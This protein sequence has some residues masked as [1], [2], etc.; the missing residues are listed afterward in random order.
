MSWS[1][2]ADRVSWSA[3]AVILDS[4][5]RSSTMP[6]SRRVSPPIR[7]A[8]PAT[9]RG[10]VTGRVSASATGRMCRACS[11]IVLIGSVGAMTSGA[12]IAVSHAPHG[13]DPDRFGRYQLDL[14][15]QPSH[16]D[17]Y[18]GLVAEVPAPH[19]LQQ[20]GP[21]ESGSGVRHQD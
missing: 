8:Y 5:N 21:G 16:V 9:S 11:I 15:P 13:R 4:S 18:C 20:F 3:P 6:E 2:T 14:L 10:S 17:G 12:V 1:G 7:C 19:L